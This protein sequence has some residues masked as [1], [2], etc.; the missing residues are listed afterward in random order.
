M[1]I[2]LCAI[3]ENLALS[4]ENVLCKVDVPQIE[5]FRG[6]ILDSGCD[7]VV[8]PANSFGFMDGGVDLLFSRYFGWG[9][10][11]ELQQK[12]QKRPLGELLVG[13][14]LAVETNDV[15][16]PYLISAPTM[17]VPDV[18]G[19]ENISLAC[20]AAIITAKDL[21]IDTIAFPGMGTGCGNV[22]YGPSCSS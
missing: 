16:I 13:E 22:P 20:R 17:R 5:V 2:K 21:P 3:D 14:A 15:D 1:L 19:F 11:A 7:V 4:W 6:D 10:Q 9:V 8:S 18:I 12:L